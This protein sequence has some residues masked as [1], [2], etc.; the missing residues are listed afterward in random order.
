MCPEL[1]IMSQIQYNS[2]SQTLVDSATIHC[3]IEIVH[4]EFSP[5]RT[6]SI[7]KLQNQVAETSLTPTTVVPASLSQLTSVVFCGSYT[8]NWE[9][10]SQTLAYKYVISVCG[11]KPKRD[12]SFIIQPHLGWP[13]QWKGKIF[14]TDGTSS[15][16]SGHGLC[17]ERKSWNENI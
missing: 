16:T 4:Q 5:S 14:L 9:G 6:K 3:K 10:K 11:Y 8:A 15:G 12:N 1:P 7:S 13:W 17:A 2:P